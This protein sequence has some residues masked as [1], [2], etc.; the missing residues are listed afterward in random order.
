MA[1]KDVELFVLEKRKNEALKKEWEKVA[2]QEDG[3]KDS[4]KEKFFNEKLYPI[5]K[6]YGFDFSFAD[7]CEYK[8][9]SKP[10][11]S[12]KEL[13]DDELF[14][15]AG[16]RTVVVEAKE[17]P[18]SWAEMQYRYGGPVVTRVDNPGNIPPHDDYN[19]R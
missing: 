14:N 13:S 6:K 8:G 10:Q 3:L 15:V 2:A 19:R 7:F 5:A 9:A 17:D 1:K 11:A 12:D 16:G 4:Q 18:S